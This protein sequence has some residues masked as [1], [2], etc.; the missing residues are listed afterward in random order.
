MAIV[1]R[2]LIHAYKDRSIRCLLTT[3]IMSGIILLMLIN[4]NMCSGIWN[5]Y[6]IK[7]LLYLKVMLSVLVTLRRIIYFMVVIGMV[8]TNGIRI[9][10]ITEIIFILTNIIKVKIV[11][12]SHGT[13]LILLMTA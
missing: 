13:H 3:C 5:L 12:G 1:M 6:Q 7:A 2:R 4:P 9:L 10:L 8:L 11:S